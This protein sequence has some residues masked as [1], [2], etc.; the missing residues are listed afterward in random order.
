MELL[1][2]LVP[3]T[4]GCSYISSFQSKHDFIFCSAFSQN[5]SFKMNMLK[6]NFRCFSFL[7]HR[8]SSLEIAR[9]SHEGLSFSEPKFVGH[10]KYDAS[11]FEKEL[12]YSTQIQ[13]KTGYDSHSSRIRLVT[14]WRRWF[15]WIYYPF[16]TV[17]SSWWHILLN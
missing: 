11:F 14:W 10:A 12:R 5:R 1:I 7:I 4:S 9:G 17:Q 2:Q 15:V 13:L 8:K 3:G 6:I 16:M